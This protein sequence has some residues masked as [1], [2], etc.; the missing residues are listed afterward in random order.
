MIGIVIKAI[1]I[2]SIPE[3]IIISSGSNGVKI[4]RSL[5]I[6]GASLARYKVYAKCARFLRCAAH[7]HTHILLMYF[8]RIGIDFS[9]QFYVSAHF[10]SGVNMHGMFMNTHTPC[11]WSYKWQN[12]NI[13]RFIDNLYGAFY[14]HTLPRR[15]CADKIL[16]THTRG[17]QGRH[18]GRLIQR[19]QHM[20]VRW[21]E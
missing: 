4:C 17:R 7:T 20:H 21:H 2:H 10:H 9:A 13:E 14:L 3:L 12:I 8:V 11:T 15:N 1:W 5:S 6:S 19:A 18:A 16:Y